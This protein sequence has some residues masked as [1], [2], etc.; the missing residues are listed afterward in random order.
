MMV[1]SKG[2]KK[3]ENA[4]TRENELDGPMSRWRLRD[5]GRLCPLHGPRE[6]ERRGKAKKSDR[7]YPIKLVAAA[8]SPAQ[9]QQGG[10]RERGG[11]GSSSS[12]N[13]GA[14]EAAPKGNAAP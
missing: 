13:S 4:S 14:A 5:G 8:S 11:G 12:S 1:I 10:T 2:K 6:G 7:I 9:A 3:L